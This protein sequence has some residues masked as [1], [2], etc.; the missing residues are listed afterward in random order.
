M[1]FSRHALFESA[2]ASSSGRTGLE[3]TRHFFYFET[4]DDIAGLDVVIVL[5]SHPT[6]VALI[7][8][9]D[10]VLEALQGFERAFV[11]DN[12]VP[13]KTYLCAAPH[14]SLSHHAAGDF[15]NLGDVEDLAN[16]R[17]SKE[18]F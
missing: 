6:L 1:L 14:S 2:H 7:D 9:A 4:L 3:R 17:V 13:Q 11:N 12:I 5:E 10:L 8:F 18:P 16:R 15:A